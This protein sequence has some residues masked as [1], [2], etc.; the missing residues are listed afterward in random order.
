MVETFMA[1][2][3]NLTSKEILNNKFSGV[4]RG[5]SPIEVDSFLDSILSDYRL[6]EN[7]LLL[8][9]K[10]A[11]EQE[12]KIKKLKEE[13][14]SLKIDIE[15]YRNRFAG[16][17]NDTNVNSN[18]IDLMQRINKLEKALWKLGADPTKI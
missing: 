9:N 15:K 3:L 1:I 10:E 14:E 4:P 8:S 2:K 12:E 5:Y 11:K 18:N 17:E 13:N 7:S 16:F 6:V